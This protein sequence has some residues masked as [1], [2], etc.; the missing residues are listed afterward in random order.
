MGCSIP[1]TNKKTKRRLQRSHLNTATSCTAKKTIKDWW[2]LTYYPF[3]VTLLPYRALFL[4]LS[5]AGRSTLSAQLSR[6]ETCSMA[7]DAKVGHAGA[8]V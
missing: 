5:S 8:A 4:A 2:E 3:K 1:S 7:T 6:E